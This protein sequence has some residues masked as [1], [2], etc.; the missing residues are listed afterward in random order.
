M[1]HNRLYAILFA[2]TVTFLFAW[3]ANIPAAAKE[4]TTTVPVCRGSNLLTS[5]KTE[6]PAAYRTILAD[7]QQ[8]PNNSGRF[9]KVERDGLTTSYLF[10]TIHMSDKRVT[11]FGD[12]VGK[13]IDTSKTVAIELT[14]ILD[15]KKMAAETIKNLKLIAFTDGRNLDS[16]L[17]APQVAAVKKALKHYGMPYASTR[18]MKPWFV[19]V[20]LALPLCEIQRKKAGFKALD[21]IIAKRGQKAG[22]RIVGLE[23]VADQFGAFAGLPLKDQINFLMSSIRM[24]PV[25]EDQIETMKQLYLNGRIG[26]VWQLAKYLTR[27]HAPKGQDASE[28]ASLEQ[29]RKE[30]IGKRNRLMAERAAPLLAQGGSFIAVGALHLPG[31]DGLVALLRQQGY[32]VTKIY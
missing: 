29:F 25:L 21:T 28:L 6:N 8:M 22:A 10:G 32:K 1:K 31:E 7:E 27:K 19:S 16:V 11:Q 18:F 14:E 20:T 30:L 12:D 13:A 2:I 3:Q 23:T 17:S 24:M 5:L 15:E 26:A 9:F 4:T